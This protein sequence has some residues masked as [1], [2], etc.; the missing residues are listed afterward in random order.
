MYTETCLEAGVQQT[1]E[2]CL[3]GK[4]KAK[5]TEQSYIEEL[6]TVE[7]GKK[8]SV[9]NSTLTCLDN[10]RDQALVKIFGKEGQSIGNWYR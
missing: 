3:R 6:E 7:D 10:K 1:G 8:T 2:K 5:Q 4:T 9:T